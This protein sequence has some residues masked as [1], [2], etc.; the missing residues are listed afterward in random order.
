M[1]RH[2]SVNEIC[3][4]PTM[5]TCPSWYEHLW[6]N[7]PLRRCIVVVVHGA[8][9]VTGFALALE[10]RFEGVVPS[11]YSTL[12][13]QTVLLLLAARMIAFLSLGLF[14]GVWRY[15]G[16][17]ELEKIVVGTALASVVAF[18]IETLA[19]V[20]RSPRSVYIGEW[21]AS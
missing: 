13:R 3:S 1:I 16:V 5:P 7:T 4:V 14:H 20:G 17:P 11:I 8:L 21:L 18:A 6:T 10:I 2:S 9:W 19:L 12:A 15:A